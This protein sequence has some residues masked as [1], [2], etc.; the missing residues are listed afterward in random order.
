MRILVRGLM[1]VAVMV[2]ALLV[3]AAPARA[4][5]CP[6]PCWWTDT[7]ADAPYKTAAGSAFF[8]SYGEHLYAFDNDADSA[9]VRVHFSVNYGGWQERTNSKGNKSQAEWN[10]EYGENLSFR[11]F[12]CISNNG[13]NI[14]GTCGPLI[15]AHT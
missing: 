5:D 12:V 10:L 9:G 8:D 1:A 15:Y 11:F 2:A 14:A 4:D 6:Y 3:T 13:T 7:K